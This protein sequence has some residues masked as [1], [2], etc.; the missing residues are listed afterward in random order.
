[1]GSASDTKESLLRRVKSRSDQAG[2]DEF[3]SCYRPSIV[4]WCRL[5]GLQPADA[6]DLTSE[7]FLKLLNA[8]TKFEYRPGGSFRSWLRTVTER[9][10]LDFFRARARSPIV[11]VEDSD[12]RT[13]M[14]QVERYDG[15][16]LA[17]PITETLFG[18]LAR[19]A[20]E[21]AR[22]RGKFAPKTWAAY[23]SWRDGEDPRHAA[24]RLGMSVA[25]I[26][27]A[28]TRVV[29]RIREELN[30]NQA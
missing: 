5:R 21:Q 2:W 13:I 6:D 29:K 23:E 26:H 22:I 19:A 27:Q 1:M 12:G 15:A 11:Q 24:V 9:A 10:I 20:E 18:H 4:T 17:D 28:R 16:D 14:N 30:L 25:S 3:T 7:V 8:M